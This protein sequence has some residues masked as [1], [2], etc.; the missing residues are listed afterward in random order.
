MK[1]RATLNQDAPIGR[2]VVKVGTSLLTRDGGR[3]D[4]ARVARLVGE[5]AAIQKTGVQVVL[6]SS[7]A[8]AAGMGELGWKKRP[9]ELSKK[10][11]A[12]AVGQPRL[13]ETYRWFFRHRQVSVAQVLLTR[14]DFE[15]ATRRKNAR[16]TLHTL[17]SAGVIPIINENDTVAVEEIRVGDNDTLA[18]YVAVQVKADLLVLLTD[19]EGL[20][21]KHPRHG[22]GRLIRYVPRI[23]P[24][25]EAVAHASTGSE[26]GT[27]GMMT[28]IRAARHATRHGVSMVIASG[29]KQGLLPLLARGLIIGTFFAPNRHN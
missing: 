23:G 15:N 4:R 7:G 1:N 25:I 10:Q 18:A 16:A 14:E 17:L 29:K 20:M 5:L 28:K 22:D 2:L 11:A 27:G 21:T 26:G 19:V 8:I 9:G 6:V 12:A 3:L 24:A 13:M